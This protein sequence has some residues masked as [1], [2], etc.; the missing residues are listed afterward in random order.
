MEAM[1]VER[2]AIREQKLEK[3]HF[4]HLLCTKLENRDAQFVLFFLTAGGANRMTPASF[5]TNYAV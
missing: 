3:G 2:P 5:F 4:M 1:G